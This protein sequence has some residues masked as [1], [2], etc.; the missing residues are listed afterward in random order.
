MRLLPGLEQAGMVIACTYPPPGGGKYT[1]SANYPARWGEMY[2]LF[3]RRGG[4]G[5]HGAEQGT[6][7]VAEQVGGTVVDIG[8]ARIGELTTAHL[9]QGLAAQLGEDL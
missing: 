1:R 6:G 4:R 5:G 9:I 7:E 2:L 3:E 8:R